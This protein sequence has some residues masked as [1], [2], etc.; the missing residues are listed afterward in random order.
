MI[1]SYKHIKV[2]IF[3]KMSMQILFQVSS[4]PI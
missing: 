1:P 3:K 4:P 2:N